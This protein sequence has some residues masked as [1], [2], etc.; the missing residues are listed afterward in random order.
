MS[1][2]CSRKAS[3]QT[4]SLVNKTV[5]RWIVGA[6]KSTMGTMSAQEVNHEPSQLL[7]NR[8]SPRRRKLT[9]ADAIADVTPD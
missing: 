5:T 1:K 6:A 7:R 8:L 3:S 9:T 4:S 2:H